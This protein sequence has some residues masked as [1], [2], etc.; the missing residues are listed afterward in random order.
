M[1]AHV[2]ALTLDLH[3]PECRSLKAKRSVVKSVIE[4]VRRR[5]GVAIAETD[6][7]DTWQRSEVALAVVASSVQHAQEVVA[8]RGQQSGGG[9]MG[10]LAREPLLLLGE[11][12]GERLAG[13]VHVEVGFGLDGARE[14]EDRGGIVQG[15]GADMKA[16]R[17]RL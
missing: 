13:G 5:Y 16:H 11:G 3:V 7:Q 2:L 6:H 9:G 12:A 17:G 10:E 1:A 8:G 15:R 4:T 14:R